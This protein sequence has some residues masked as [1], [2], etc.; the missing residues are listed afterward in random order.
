TLFKYLLHNVYLVNDGAEKDLNNEILKD[1][2]TLIGKSGKFNKSK[3]T[4]SG[5][6]VG[7]FEGKRIGR[8][9][10]LENLNKEVK[11]LENQ[12]KTLK[13][14]SLKAATRSQDISV[15]NAEIN[16]L[17]NELISVKTKQEQYQS[18]IT[19][20]QNRKLDIEQKLQSIAIELQKL[21]PLIVEINQ[22]K[23]MIS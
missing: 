19:N 4:L 12:I 1:E 23:L 20:S 11:D 16:Q 5:G 13:I 8:A 14:T 7:L 17:Q 22:Q 2:I 9:K 10:N 18:F 6:S 3:F 15:I 21:Q